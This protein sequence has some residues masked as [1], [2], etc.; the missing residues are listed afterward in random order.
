LHGCAFPNSKSFSN[1]KDELCQIL[2]AST[3]IRMCFTNIRGYQK[4]TATITL[5]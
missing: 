5:R 4:S 1:H 2:E 3:I